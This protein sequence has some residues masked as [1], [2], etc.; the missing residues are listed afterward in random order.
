MK[1]KSKMFANW[2]MTHAKRVTSEKSKIQNRY[3]IVVWFGHVFLRDTVSPQSP[4]RSL[5]VVSKIHNKLHL[6][7]F[8]AFCLALV[9]LFVSFFIHG[10]LA[11]LG[12]L[13]TQTYFLCHWFRRKLFSAEPV[14]EKIRLRSQARTWVDLVWVSCGMG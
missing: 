12:S 6:I 9:C 8:F 13:R 5:Y 4:Y 10:E 11:D 7:L 14:T 2:Q 1:L 3:R